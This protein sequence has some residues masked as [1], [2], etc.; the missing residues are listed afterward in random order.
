M[1]MPSV[2]SLS[3]LLFSAFTLTE[4]EQFH[5]KY[6]T[7]GSTLK[8]LNPYHKVRLHSHDIKYGSGSGQ[9]SVTAVES[10]DDHNSYWQ[11]RPKPGTSC[12]R[13]VPV[14][15][16]QTIQLMHVA[17][18][19]NLHGHHFRSPLSNNLEVSAFG[20]DGVG[21]AGDDWTVICKTGNWSREERIRLKNVVTGS[22]LHVNGDV[23]GRPIQGQREV[24]AHDHPNEKNYWQAG[25]G[26]FIKPALPIHSRLRNHDEF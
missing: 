26:I 2:T 7:C 24:S 10:S 25:E 4:T 20:E 8:L 17:T 6:V 19:R 18:R 12:F 9:Q 16:D 14:K 11:I 22:Y 15:C 23:Y 1:V 3:L 13:G 21:D 5:Y